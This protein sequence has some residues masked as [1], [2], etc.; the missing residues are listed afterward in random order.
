LKFLN[1]KKKKDKTSNNKSVSGEKT[2]VDVT[3]RAENQLYKGSKQLYSESIEENLRCLFQRLPDPNLVTEE[4]ILGSRSQTKVVIAYLKDIANPGIV[5]EVKDRLNKIRAEIIPDTSYIERNIQDSVWSPF[6]QAELVA[7]VDLTLVALSQG[8]IAIFVDYCPEIII[9]PTTFFDILDTP[10]DA[11]RRWFVASSFFR[12][13]RFICFFIAALL[14]GFYIALTSFHPEL[15]PTVLAVIL[16]STREGT[17]FPVYLEAFILMGIAELVRM[18]TLRMPN[19]TGLAISIFSGVTLVLTGILGNI[20]SGP[21][22][23]VVGLTII[24]S[25]TIPGLDLRSSIRIIQFFTMV[26]A[27]VF[28]LFGLALSV[29][30]ILIHLST[31]KSFGIPYMTPLG[32]LELS[33]WGHTVLREPTVEMPQDKTYKP[34]KKE[35]H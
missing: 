11:Y 22:L 7:K 6:P 24:A 33:S 9:V 14:P 4:F 26:M 17:P 30:Y 12:I 2:V 20:I 19:T 28:G 27:T 5:D 1:W 25:F 3:P 32:P 13:A 29:F 31:L 15:I 34:Q 16:T 23:I 35:E 8:R 18:V 21:I 10:E